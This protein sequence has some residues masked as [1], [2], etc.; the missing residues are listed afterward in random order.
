M[1]DTRD[2]PMG[3]DGFAFVEFDD[4]RDAE[5]AVRWVQSIHGGPGITLTSLFMCCREMD[6]YEL[7]GRR[8]V[9]EHAR[10]STARPRATGG[11]GAYRLRVEGLDA[12]TS[13]QDLK[14]F[15]RKGGNSVVFTDVYMDRGKKSG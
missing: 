15:A 3:L 13:W 1:T 7:D 12:R 8:I 4:T 10:G 11:K 5:D 9:C 2:N 14:D 6:G